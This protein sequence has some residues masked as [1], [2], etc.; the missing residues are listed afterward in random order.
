MNIPKTQQQPSAHYTAAWV[1]LLAP[2]FSIF[3]SLITT[4]KLH[5]KVAPLLNTLLKLQCSMHLFTDDPVLEA[6]L[7]RGSVRLNQSFH[8]SFPS[9]RLKGSSNIGKLLLRWKTHAGLVAPVPAVFALEEGCYL[10]VASLN[11]CWSLGHRD[12][13]CSRLLIF[14]VSFHVRLTHTANNTARQTLPPQTCGFE[15][16][17]CGEQHPRL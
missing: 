2:V 3:S 4:E 5:S 17:W 1:S 6:V 13:K 9:S 16:A 8:P 11:K 7:N 10:N 12:L 14:E 15:C